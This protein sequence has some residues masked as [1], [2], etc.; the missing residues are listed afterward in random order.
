MSRYNAYVVN[1][2]LVSV[3]LFKNASAGKE[4]SAM[5]ALMDHV[6]TGTAGDIVAY[7]VDTTQD[8]YVRVV[9]T[10]EAG[11]FRLRAPEGWQ[12][13][14]LE[15]SYVIVQPEEKA[16]TVA[17]DTVSIVKDRQH[18]DYIIM[19]WEMIGD[20]TTTYL[21]PNPTEDQI[22]HVC[23]AANCFVG[24]DNTKDQKR[25]LNRIML[26]ISENAREFGKA[27]KLKAEIIDDW[28]TIWVNNK[29]DNEKPLQVSG[30][31][32][33]INAGIYL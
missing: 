16:I 4:D 5:E 13:G 1:K 31:V 3:G 19:L 33:F 10:I 25:A 22:K 18:V 21:I 27:M 20:S 17:D 9:R 7:I 28:A 12:Q 26:A 15:D 8:R 29:V 23:N 30:N 6:K 24:G 32:L 2:G 14:K 11:I